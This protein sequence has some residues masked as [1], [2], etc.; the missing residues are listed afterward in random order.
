MLLSLSRLNK[1]YPEMTNEYGFAQLQPD[2]QVFVES[3]WMTK[4]YYG[5]DQD[6]SS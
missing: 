4:G 1:D 3:C 5:L 2:V 6:P